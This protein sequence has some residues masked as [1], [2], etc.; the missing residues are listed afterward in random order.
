MSS[1]D[2][3]KCLRSVTNYVSFGRKILFRKVGRFAAAR[4]HSWTVQLDSKP[5]LQWP[6]REVCQ[7]QR[8]CDI[9]PGPLPIVFK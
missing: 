9:R 8:E 1:P 3:P 2:L 7:S 4:S 6:W 5:L